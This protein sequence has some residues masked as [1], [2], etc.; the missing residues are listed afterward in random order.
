MSKNIC[1]KVSTAKRAQNQFCN[2]MKPLATLWTWG[3]TWYF[4]LHCVWSWASI[5]PGRGLLQGEMADE[6]RK[7]ER[8]YWAILDPSASLK[9]HWRQLMVSVSHQQ[10]THSPNE[11]SALGTTESRYCYNRTSFFTILF[12]F[13]NSFPSKIPFLISWTEFGS[14]P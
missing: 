9:C 4:S 6:D 8:K 11:T 14:L 13:L 5:H 1:H 12:F 3:E 10:H 2:I 7:G